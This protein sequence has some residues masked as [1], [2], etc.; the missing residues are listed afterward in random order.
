MPKAMCRKI[1]TIR[2]HG[3]EG[4]SPGLRGTKP[5]DFG[6]KPLVRARGE[7]PDA[8]VCGALERDGGAKG[9]SP[10]GK[11]GKCG[12]TGLLPDSDGDNALAQGV[13]H[14][15][16]TIMNVKLVHKAGF[17][18]LDGLGADD[19]D[20]GNRLG[21]VPLGKKLEHFPFSACQLI[22]GITPVL[23]RSAL[24]EALDQ[25]LGHRWW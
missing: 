12:Q 15:V 16:N 7:T 19:K 5:L 21:S 23:K 8:L 13:L 18:A 14:Q 4:F 24:L 3:E 2:F 11:G 25:Q 17:V 1:M 20:I 10:V 22:I 9:V 6:G